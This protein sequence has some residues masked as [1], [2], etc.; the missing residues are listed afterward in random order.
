MQWKLDKSKPPKI[1]P[2]AFLENEI[3][4]PINMFETKE[5][6]EQADV[7]ANKK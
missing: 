7:S 5:L 2:C 3:P 1:S 6:K 4:Q